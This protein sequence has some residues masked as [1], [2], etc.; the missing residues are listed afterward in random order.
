MHI[1][2]RPIL[3]CPEHCKNVSSA[4][5][6]VELSHCFSDTTRRWI[7][8]KKKYCLPGIGFINSVTDV[9]RVAWF[10]R[11]KDDPL[12]QTWLWILMKPEWNCLLQEI[13]ICTLGGVTKSSTFC[14]AC[15]D[16]ECLGKCSDSVCELGLCPVTYAFLPTTEFAKSK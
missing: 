1:I 9:L 11:Q 8:W 10:I 5:N 2:M 3:A 15:F 7:C 12:N 14:F 16:L 6:S 13:R 4:I